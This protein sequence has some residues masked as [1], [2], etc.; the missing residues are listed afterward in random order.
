MSKSALGRGLGQLM[1]DKKDPANPPSVEAPSLEPASPASPP[2]AAGPG[3]G[4]L[5]RGGR[6]PGKNVFAGTSAESDPG[7]EKP[8]TPKPVLPPWYFYA[9]D[10]LLIAF[11][12]MVV[13]KNPWPLKTG[14]AVLCMAVVALAGVL[15]A[16]GVWLSR[17]RD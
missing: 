2:P 5:L 3:V 1:G 14:P 9:A 10:L 15:G 11:A 6:K 17:K 4:S 16:M 13:Y 7:A 12:L 8:A